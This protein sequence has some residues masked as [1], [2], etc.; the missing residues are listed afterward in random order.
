MKIDSIQHNLRISFDTAFEVYE[1]KPGTLQLIS[2]ICH[3][4]GDMLD[5]YLEKSPQGDTFIRICDFGLTLMRLSYD[6]E[7]KSPT[8]K[9]ILSDIL[10]NNGIVNESDNLYTDVRLEDLHKGILRYASGIHKVCNIRYWKQE[11]AE[12]IFQNNLKIH[13]TTKMSAFSPRQ[14]FRPYGQA[15]YRVDW[16]FEYAKLWFFAYGVRGGTQAKNAIISLFELQNLRQT[17]QMDTPYKSIIIRDAKTAIAK[18]DDEFLQETT[19]HYYPSLQAFEHNGI[20]DFKRYS[21]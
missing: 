13:I 9:R 11:S 7:P 5:I 19:N 1:R 16:A 12:R 17:I 2:P 18:K 21:L 6:D 10:A 3:E 20:S 4:D 15:R 14:N 8:H